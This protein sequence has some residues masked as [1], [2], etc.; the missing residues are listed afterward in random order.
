MS[1]ENSRFHLNERKTDLNNLESNIQEI[2]ET[3]VSVKSLYDEDIKKIVDKY[4][5]TNILLDS[6]IETIV[7][8]Y[9]DLGFEVTSYIVRIDIENAISEIKT[10]MA[11]SEMS[12]LQQEEL[13]NNSKQI[14]SVINNIENDSTKYD[15]EYFND[16]RL[17]ADKNTVYGVVSELD[18]EDL[19]KKY[20]EKGYITN[21]E[22]IL[23]DVKAI[24]ASNEYKKKTER[25]TQD[26]MSAFLDG[27]DGKSR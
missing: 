27:S 1:L 2:D 10:Q 20:T 18:I 21:K 6:D 22:V 26:L 13:Y 11:S 12:S 3:S 24:Q 8:K 9:S 19:V 5:V 25:S 17:V 15:E 16:I 7:K 4:F 14:E 23:E